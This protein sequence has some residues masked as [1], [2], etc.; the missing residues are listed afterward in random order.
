M[1]T[2]NEN[3]QILFD[4]FEDDEFDQIKEALQV[5]ILTC[6]N[7]L[8]DPLGQNRLKQFRES[9]ES[10]LELLQTSYKKITGHKL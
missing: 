9:N 1:K 10:K 7:Y 8:T 4:V 3:R 2:A 5:Q 6:K